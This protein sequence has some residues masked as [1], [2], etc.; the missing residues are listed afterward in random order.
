MGI[1]VPKF[2]SYRNLYLVYMSEHIKRFVTNNLLEKGYVHLNNQ[3]EENLREIID[4]LGQI[5]YVTDVIVKENSKGLVTSDRPLD[6]HTDHHKAKYIVWYCYKQTDL[7][8]ETILADAKDVYEQ[9]PEIYK[10]QLKSIELYEH[11]VFPDDQESYPLVSI[12][13]EGNYRFYYSFWLVKKSD[14]K[15]PALL[16]FQ[17]LLK[18][19]DPI[20]I[21]LKEMDILIID[22]HRILHGRTA[23]EGNKDR[24]LKRFWVI[25][26]KIIST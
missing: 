6:Y 14:K 5:I 19:N 24:F 23:I 26:K 7:G 20:K 17:R 8:G 18:I 9:M 22:N 15:N 12:D 1:F 3:S 25:E 21:K 13:K 11:K 10:H 4:W 2:L 16:E